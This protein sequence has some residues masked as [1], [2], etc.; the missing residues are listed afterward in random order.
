MKITIKKLKTM[1]GMDWPAVDCDV[2][3]DGKAFAQAHDDGSGG[4]LFI[5][6]IGPDYNK[7]RDLLKQ[8]ENFVKKNHS[9][10]LDEFVDN[11]IDEALLDKEDKKVQKDFQKGICFGKDKNT[12]VLHNWKKFKTLKDLADD[13]RGKVAIQKAIID[14]KKELKQGEKILNADILKDLGFKV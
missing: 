12:F 13:P 1:R 7:N 6:P 4:G 5:Q 8:V 11:L 14:I 2:Y 3:V 10:D 9:I